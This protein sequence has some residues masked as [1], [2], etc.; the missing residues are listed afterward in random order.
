MTMQPHRAPHEITP[1]D[2]H[3]R[4][5]R[6]EVILVDVREAHEYAAERIH[7]ALLL[8]LSTFDPRA[9]PAGGTRPVI[10]QCGTGKRSGMALARCAEAGVAVDTHLAGGIAAW[11]QA[12]LATVTLDPGTGKVVDRQ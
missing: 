11:K 2:L 7:G 1:H 4:L 9:L 10:L 6:H 8:P 12:G 3:D 5:L